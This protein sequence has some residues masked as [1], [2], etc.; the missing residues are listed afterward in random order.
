M[1]ELERYKLAYRLVAFNVNGDT[2][3]MAAIAA[4]VIADRPLNLEDYP[5][6]TAKEVRRIMA[7]DA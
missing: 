7:L 1:T 3:D 4:D 5:P 6:S 2:E